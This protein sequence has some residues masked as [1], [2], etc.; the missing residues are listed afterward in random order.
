MSAWGMKRKLYRC[1]ICDGEHYQEKCTLPSWYIKWWERFPPHARRLSINRFLKKY[2]GPE[3]MNPVLEGYTKE[4]LD[5]MSPAVRKA[6]M[7]EK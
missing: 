1:R 6:I 7:G 2:Y 4:E 3:R 5:S